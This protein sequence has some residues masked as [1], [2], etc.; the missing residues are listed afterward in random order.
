VRRRVAWC[1][2]CEA[3]ASHPPACAKANS[4]EA[5]CAASSASASATEGTPTTEAGARSDSLWTV[6]GLSLIR[7]QRSIRRRYDETVSQH[8]HGSDWAK[9]AGESLARAGYRRGGARRAVVD[10]LAEQ[11]CAL[12]AQ[13]IEDTLRGSD[14][15]VGRASVYR[16]LD[17]LERLDLVS[18]IDVGGSVARFEAVHTDPER[19]HDHLVCTDC[20][21]VI[22]FRDDELERTLRR[23]AGR[24]EFAVDQH[25]VVLHGHC[26]ACRVQTV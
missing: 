7:R 21:E 8:D 15:R 22:P 2:G 23:V 5:R 25:E 6:I 26:G 9:L 4:Q 16:V 3:P 19:H 11:P 13:E 1:L 14:K 10:L 17:E 24:V 18:R 12:S 20:G